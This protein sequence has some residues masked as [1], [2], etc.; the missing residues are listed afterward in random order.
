[1]F[2][3][4]VPLRHLFAA[5][6]LCS[7]NYF[8][9]DVNSGGSEILRV[10]RSSLFCVENAPMLIQQSKWFGVFPF[11]EVLQFYLHKAIV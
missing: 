8:F 11:P 2:L 4:P 10:R 1:M 6:E 3:L 9:S 5:W 7:W